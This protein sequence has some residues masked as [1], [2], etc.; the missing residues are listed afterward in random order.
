VNYSF[1]V[2]IPVLHEA[3]LIN[4]TIG[5]VYQ[6]GA[7][8]DI[9]IIVVDG[10]PEGETINVIRNNEIIKVISPKGRGRQMNKGA[11]LARGE[12]L[13]F[14]HTDTELP[15]DAFRTIS[16]VIDKQGC[17]GGAFDLGIKSGRLIFRLI[18]KTVS[19][20]TRL[21]GIPYGDQAIFIKKEI[22]KKIKGYRE[23][24]L[25]E[26]VEFMRRVKKSGCH[27]CIIPEKVKTSPRRWEKEGVLY[28]T[29]R[30]W[31]LISLYLSGV[32][33]EKLVKFYYRGW[34][35][36]E[37]KGASCLKH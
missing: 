28:C 30:N 5:H 11:S 2:I 32:N 14:L 25:M 7:G 19:I 13:L 37:E 9:E 17:A 36:T 22:F 26:D 24:P 34:N 18:E 8:F 21:T 6:R 1:S 33:P 16:S 15:A 4:E 27:L 29:L 35:R 23:I 31:T 20:R 12:I 3:L 10:D